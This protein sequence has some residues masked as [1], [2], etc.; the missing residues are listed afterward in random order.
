M[1]VLFL[2]LVNKTSTT[3]VF[4]LHKLLMTFILYNIITDCKLI[5]KKKKIIM[6][7]INKIL[8]IEYVT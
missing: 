8:Y 6:I 2:N 5:K 4:R 3:K 7:N 1:T